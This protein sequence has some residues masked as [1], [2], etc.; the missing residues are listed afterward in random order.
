M[1]PIVLPSYTLL[2]P[3][4]MVSYAAIFNAFVTPLMAT[5]RV[6]A[7]PPHRSRKD[8]LPERRGAHVG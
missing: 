7:F 3:L 1:P 2:L 8:A 5:R 4:T 6:A